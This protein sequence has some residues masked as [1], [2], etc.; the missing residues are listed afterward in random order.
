MLFLVP[1]VHAGEQRI[2]LVYR[3]DRPI[4]EHLEVFV[5][6]DRGDFQ[7][8][9]GLGEQPG[10]FQIDP[11][12]IFSG[13]HGVSLALKERILSPGAHGTGTVLACFGRGVLVSSDGGPLRCALPGRKLRPVCGDRV[14]WRLSP[15]ADGP[16]VE[17]LEARRNLLE[18]IEARGR[19]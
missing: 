10:H 2:A 13:F 16:A 8:N 15:S 7:D 12:K 1:V 11:D 9:V 3:Q 5:G 17:T 19:A 6:Y 4:G 14:T 18:R